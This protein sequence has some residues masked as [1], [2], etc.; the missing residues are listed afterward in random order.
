MVS[1]HSAPDRRQPPCH[2]LLVED[3]QDSRAVTERAL[4]LAGFEV[5]AVDAHGAVAAAKFGR[6]D[7]LII[8]SGRH[9]KRGADLLQ[10]L[11]RWVGQVP[12][13]AFVSVRHTAD[14]AELLRQGYTHVLEKPATVEEMARAVGSACG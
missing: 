7:V 5:T 12:A 10:H 8:G 14:P 3:H 11:R 6:Y 13:V 4:Q 9:E 2:V 1:F